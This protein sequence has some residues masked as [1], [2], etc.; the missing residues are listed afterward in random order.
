MTPMQLGTSAEIE[1]LRNAAAVGCLLGLAYGVNAVIRRL[2]MSRAVWFLCDIAYSLFFGAVF[3]LFTLSQTDHYRGFVLAGMLAGTILW[4]FSAG[5]LLVPAACFAVNKLL[6]P[7]AVG[8]YKLCR[9]Y[10]AKIVKSH[11]NSQMLK[12]MS[13]ST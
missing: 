11:T 5:R 3:F 1:A 2:C 9:K 7:V 8:I 12:K 10:T 4:H 13:E 6:K